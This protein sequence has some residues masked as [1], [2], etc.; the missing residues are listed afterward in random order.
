[1]KKTYFEAGACAGMGQS[2]KRQPDTAEGSLLLTAVRLVALPLRS[3]VVREDQRQGK[4][5]KDLPGMREGVSCCS[6]TAAGDPLRRK[7]GHES[8]DR[9]RQGD[10][11]GAG[12][13]AAGA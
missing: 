6:P 7:E 3:H 13:L 9:V 1:M 2:R 5:W 10:R 8:G 11:H 12:D 4:T